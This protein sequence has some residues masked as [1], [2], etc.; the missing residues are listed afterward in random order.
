MLGMAGKVLECEASCDG[1]LFC[2]ASLL[3]LAQPFPAVR[4]LELPQTVGYGRLTPNTSDGLLPSQSLQDLKYLCERAPN[5]RH[6]LFGR[7]SS[8]VGVWA[9]S[10]AGATVTAALLSLLENSGQ[11]QNRSSICI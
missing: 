10:I 11:N 2:Q 6:W 5:W 8:G 3:S 4:A 9:A 7:Q 1:D